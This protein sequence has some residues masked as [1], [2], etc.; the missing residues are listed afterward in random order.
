[1]AVL[2][3][4]LHMTHGE[5]HRHLHQQQQPAHTINISI[6][7]NKSPHISPATPL[8]SHHLA[9]LKHTPTYLRHA[10]HT[11][12]NNQQATKQSPSQ[13]L[14]NRDMFSI[15]VKRPIEK[16]LRTYQSLV[17]STTRWC[18]RNRLHWRIVQKYERCFKWW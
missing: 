12:M 18:E 8:R 7:H 11:N 17:E 3:H 4:N 6:T 9:Q 10:T 5:H 15:T 14:S 2:P 1:M 16:A 13:M